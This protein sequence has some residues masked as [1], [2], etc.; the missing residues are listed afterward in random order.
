MIFSHFPSLQGW[1]SQSILL[2]LGVCRQALNIITPFL[3][4]KAHTG[5]PTA[6]L[7]STQ[8]LWYWVKARVSR[9]TSGIGG[10]IWAFWGAVYL[11]RMVLWGSCNKE[12]LVGGQNASDN[13]KTTWGQNASNNHKLLGGQNAPDHLQSVSVFC[14]P[15]LALCRVVWESSDRQHGCLV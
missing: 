9:I 5:M 14:A 3:H 11:V 10:T 12:K 8:A 2:A 4:T 15:K 6:D 7:S 1:N 13:Y